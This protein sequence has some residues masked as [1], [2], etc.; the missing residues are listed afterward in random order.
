[1]KMSKMFS[2]ISAVLFL[3]CLSGCYYSKENFR[4]DNLAYA[5][6]DS[7]KV[8][9]V[10]DYY[11][12]GNEDTMTINIPDYIDGYKVKYLGGYLGRGAPDPFCVNIPW[13]ISEIYS[14]E[15]IHVLEETNVKTLHFILNIGANVAQMKRVNMRDYYHLEEPDVFLRVAVTV[16]CS[17]ENKWFYSMDG[18]LYN[19]ADDT[20][21]EDFFYYEDYKDTVVSFDFLE[22]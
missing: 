22:S 6:S 1:M 12:D 2:V 19:K 18:K 4:E 10:S 16:N 13:S 11:W 5:K 15:C 17:S 3:I 7:H 21:I 20:L 8:C 9:Y 14:E